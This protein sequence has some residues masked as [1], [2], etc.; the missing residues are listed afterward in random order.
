MSPREPAE[1]VTVDREVIEGALRV[2]RSMQNALENLE[3]A[4]QEQLPPA[5]PH[6]RIAQ[7]QT[8]PHP[9]SDSERQ[10]PESLEADA[11]QMASL[12]PPRSAIRS[13]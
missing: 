9:P 12:A 4:V 6:L 2:I 3:Y 11:S 13:L 10:Q 7:P 1:Q 8:E 5:R